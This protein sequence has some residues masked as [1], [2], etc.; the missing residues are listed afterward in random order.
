MQGTS[1]DSSGEVQE[2]ED[3]NGVKP[4]EQASSDQDL[5]TLSSP[6]YEIQELDC[7]FCDQIMTH[8]KNTEKASIFP[9]KSD[10]D[11]TLLA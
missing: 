5:G 9:L 11:S 3:R 4:Q 6:R 1:K 7:Q 10:R 2:E 8:L